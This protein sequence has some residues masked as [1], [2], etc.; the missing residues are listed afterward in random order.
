MATRV[1]FFVALIALCS[2]VLGQNSTAPVIRF[3][4]SQTTGGRFAI[5]DKSLQE[6]Y[7]WWLEWINA[8]GGITVG[9][10]T[11]FSFGILLIVSFRGE[12]RKVELYTLEDGSSTDTVTII[13]GKSSASFIVLITDI[14]IRT[15][16]DARC[17]TKVRLSVWSIFSY[18]YL[19]YLEDVGAG[20]RYLWG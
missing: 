1:I 7:T 3:C 6:G 17:I 8:R 10:V 2:L 11:N 12:K 14:C 16:F 20:P 9:Y 5:V 18:K 15:L 19:A 13:Y 4:R